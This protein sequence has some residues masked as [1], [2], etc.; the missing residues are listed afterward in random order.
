MGYIS[1]PLFDVHVCGVAYTNIPPKIEKITALF[2]KSPPPP[3]QRLKDQYNIQVIRNT[4]I[5]IIYIQWI[6][7]CVVWVAEAY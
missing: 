4:D 5:I 7:I 3:P 1:S 6:Y 2:A